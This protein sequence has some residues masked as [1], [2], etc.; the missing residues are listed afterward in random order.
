MDREVYI[1]SMYEVDWILRGI[2]EKIDKIGKKEWVDLRKEIYNGKDFDEKKR[3]EINQSDSVYYWK[4]NEKKYEVE[5]LFK[6]VEEG[7]KRILAVFEYIEKQNVHLP[8]LELV[9]YASLSMMFFCM[10]NLDKNEID[11]LYCIIENKILQM[12]LKKKEIEYLLIISKVVYEKMF[13]IYNKIECDSKW[14]ENDENEYNKRIIKLLKQANSLILNGEI[15]EIFREIEDV[16]KFFKEPTEERLDNLRNSYFLKRESW[17]KHVFTCDSLKNED[18]VFRFLPHIRFV[19]GLDNDSIMMKDIFDKKPLGYIKNMKEDHLQEVIK[20]K[21]RAYWR[22]FSLP[23]EIKTGKSQGV[24]MYNLIFLLSEKMEL[25]KTKNAIISDFTHRYKN[26]ETDNIYNIA[27]A[28]NS[29][30]SNEEL[31]DYGRELLLEYYNKQMMSRE[32]AMLSLE[33]KDNFKELRYV[34]E[35]SITTPKDGISIRNLVDEALKRILLRILLVDEEKRVEDIRGKYERNDIDTFNL[36]EKYECDIIRGGKSSIDWVNCHMNVLNIGISEEWKSV[37]FRKFS[38]G[39]VF[40]MSMIMELLFNMFSYAD[41]RYD[42]NIFFQFE[43]N[44]GSSY[45][46]IKT[47]NK[48]DYG[49]KSNGRKGLSSR[50]RV[51][52]KINYGR[53]YRWYESI[54]KEYVKDNTE[55]IVTARICANIFGGNINEKNDFMD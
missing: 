14:T 22:A 8:E 36:L 30:P 43:K 38:E 10:R 31:E 2:R 25:E 52:S 5:L 19:I 20:W 26:Y 49:I 4:K 50:N 29:N 46:I 28:L 55:C 53:N 32:I 15:V 37:F 33:H 18:N 48:V 13:Y 44:N 7:R 47:K 16:E 9:I 3:I 11:S 27:N 17:I 40:L 34:I 35:K 6:Q 51:L 45:F 12:K 24:L 21:E 54:I 41:I 1:N 42:M 23:Y 39:S